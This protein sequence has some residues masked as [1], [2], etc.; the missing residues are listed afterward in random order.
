MSSVEDIRTSNAKP[1]ASVPDTS[2][3]RRPSRSMSIISMSVM[4]IFRVDCD[5]YVR[6]DYSRA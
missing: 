1:M 4:P 3:T 2:V 5:S 6:M